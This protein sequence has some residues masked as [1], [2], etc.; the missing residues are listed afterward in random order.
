MKKR[1]QGFGLVE[2]IIGA[3]IIALA[4][5]GMTQ[6]SQYGLQASKRVSDE[7]RAGFLLSEGAEAARLI[8]DDGFSTLSSLTA[9]TSYYLYYNNTTNKWQATSTRQV[10]DSIFY[11]T[12]AV[13]PVYRDS[14]DDI[15][16]NGGTLDA[17]TLLIRI[18]VAWKNFNA[19][20]TKSQ[21]IY[22]TNI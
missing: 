2:V 7:Q 9:S 16:T 22:L 12:F 11:R 20:S 6:A 10:I 14:N 3:S 4:I 19:T 17:G 1:S 21:D 18:S 8:R 5:V 15:T 13:W